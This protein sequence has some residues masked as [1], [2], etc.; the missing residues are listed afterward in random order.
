MIFEAVV[1]VAW[2][3]PVAFGLAVDRHASR[4]QPP[5]RS[6]LR[7][8][9]IARS[10]SALLTGTVVVQ[11]DR[12][13]LRGTIT[14]TADRGVVIAVDPDKASWTAVAVSGTSPRW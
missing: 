3:T 5:G 10:W 11:L 6:G 12:G 2:E 4:P 1:K 14:T 7:E 13:V 8:V 9:C